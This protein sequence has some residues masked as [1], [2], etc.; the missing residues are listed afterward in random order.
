MWDMSLRKK[1]ASIPW[2]RQLQVLSS[3]HSS[4]IPQRLGYNWAQH[5]VCEG[6]FAI[7]WG[8]CAL[9]PATRTTYQSTASRAAEAVNDFSRKPHRWYR[10]RSDERLRGLAVSTNETR[11]Q[12]PVIV[13]YP[14]RKD[15]SLLTSRATDSACACELYC[16]PW[17][18]H[19]LQYVNIVLK[20][21]RILFSM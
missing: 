13:I 16:P 6:R 5:F 2:S 10:V 21:A 3:D 19:K 18:K 20:V 15:G 11:S 7:D 12:E 14:N 1:L 9:Q 17:P 8:T 4:L